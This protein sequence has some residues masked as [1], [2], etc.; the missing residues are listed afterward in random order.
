M[1]GELLAGR[2][3]K[4][5]GSEMYHFYVTAISKKTGTAIATEGA[6]SVSENSE[7]DAQTKESQP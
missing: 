1:V 3:I 2:V 4:N 5:P 7:S 6:S